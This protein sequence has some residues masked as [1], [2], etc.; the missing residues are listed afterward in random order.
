[1]KSKFIFNISQ[2]LVSL[3]GVGFIRPASATWGSLFAGVL[4]YIFFPALAIP[5]K[6]FIVLFT[7][8]LGW[9][10]TEVVIKKTKKQDPYFVVID[11]CVGM[12]I[13][14]IYLTQTWWHFVVALIFF[15]IFDIAKFWPASY[16][17][18]KHSSF[19]VMFDDVLMAI[20]ALIFTELTIALLL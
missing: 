17:D 3:F 10:A 5:T 18:K 19:S 16:F 8:F 1:M 11:E 12:M 7:F 20:P 15:R 9:F 13:T 14:S 6:L 2:A 4:L